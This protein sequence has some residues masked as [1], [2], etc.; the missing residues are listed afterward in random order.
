MDA[1][2]VSICNIRA[3]EGTTNNVTPDDVVMYGTVRTYKKEV[4][5]KIKD[6]LRCIIESVSEGYGC[7]GELNY[8]D[9]LEVT[10]NNPILYE[11]A[12]Q[13]VKGAGAVPVDPVPSTGGEDFAAYLAGKAPGFF[14]W[15]GVRNVDKDCLY[16]WHSPKFRADEDAVTIGAGT[17]AMTAF[18]AIQM[19]R[20]K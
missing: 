17:Y 11:T 12:Y 7:R 16:P 10:D 8:I 6:R 15:L 1:A 2:V 3:G 20:N 4:K 5:Q 13:A 14:Y 18:C 9:E 19:Y